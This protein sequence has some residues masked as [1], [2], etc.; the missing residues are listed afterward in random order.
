MP[1]K[2]K[3]LKRILIWRYKYISER[4][5]IYVLS[6]L[7]GF[8]AG[9]GTAILKN[10]TFLI[11][12]I[13][14]GKLIKEI[15]YSLYFIFP[16]IGL[17]LVYYIKKKIIKKEIG[18]GI[19]TT[20]HAVSKKN[21]IIE[22][23]KIYASLITAPITVGFGG[24]AG[25]QGPAVSTGAA[26][27][28]TVAQMFHMNSK[29]RMLLIGCATTGAMSSMFK[30]PVAAIIFAVEIFSLD[31]A[32]ASLVPLLLASVSAVITSYFFFEKDALLGFKLVDAF[33]TKDTFYYIL[34]G[35]GTGVAS[36]YFSKI[37]FIIT[38]FFKRI[39]KPIH[40][41]ILGGMAIGVMLYL[42][43]PLYGEGYGLINNL[44]QGNTLGALKDIPYKVDFTNVWIVI[45][46]L[47]LITI[48][49]AIA[50]TTTFAAGGVGGIFVPTLVM[51]SALGNVSAKIINALGGEVS[52][53]NF[54]LIGMTGLMAGVLHAPLTAIFLIAEITGGYDLFVPLMLVAAISYA[55]TKYFISNSIYTVELAEKGELITHDKD[56]NVLM[57]MQITKLIEKNFKVVHPDMLL[58]DM[59]KTAVAKS[60]RNIF[61]VVNSNKQFIGIVLLDD[62][63]P[64]MFDREMYNSVTVETLMRAAPE[65]IFHDDSVEQ[66]MQKFKESDAWNLPVIKNEKY[67][68]FISKSKLLTAYRNK[69][70]EVTA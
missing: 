55:F 3:L 19:S 25:L 34:L 47:L 32:F 30:A 57:M 6:I 46:F 54:T 26:L 65:I 18:H 64:I 61:P 17:I 43:P 11:E 10:L 8:L 56:K 7:V 40:R 31:L 53:S 49:K 29:T 33:Q 9:L 4:Q 37:Y 62:L 16:I 24:S 14:E 1:T 42:I 20:L 36:V 51:G 68:G 44:L 13:L 41:L 28:S 58:G 63:R 45:L 66:V 2:S 22:R 59:L 70:I 69:L 39:K 35:L 5:F 27:G 48:F 12:Y 38:N 21:G 50:M 67:V 52:E 15:H 60:T 23:Y